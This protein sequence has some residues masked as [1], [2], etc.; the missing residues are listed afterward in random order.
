MWDWSR[1]RDWIWEEDGGL[2]GG[3]GDRWGRGW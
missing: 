3:R 1:P 2:K